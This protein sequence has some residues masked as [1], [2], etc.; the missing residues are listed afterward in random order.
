MKSNY[1]RLREH[2]TQYWKFARTLC[3][4]LKICENIVPN[5]EHVNECARICPNTHFPDNFPEYVRNTPVGQ[6]LCTTLYFTRSRSTTWSWRQTSDGLLSPEWSCAFDDRQGLQRSFGAPFVPLT[7][8][9]HRSLSWWSAQSC[10]LFLKT[11]QIHS[12][13][14]PI[15]EPHSQSQD[16]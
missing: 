1:E 10:T 8:G 6:F 12:S 15:L 11:L 2:C 3:L 9:K 16:L 7:Y 4:I 13:L 5:I 14:M